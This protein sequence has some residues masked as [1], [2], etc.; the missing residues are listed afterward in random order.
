V[1]P[2]DPPPR[3]QGSRK[4]Q[5]PY[6]NRFETIWEYEKS[7]L[8]GRIDFFSFIGP[9]C[10]IC[11]DSHCYRQITPYWRYAIELF[12]EF[13]KKRIPI[14]RFLCRR[15]P[16]TFSLL[17]IQLIPYCQYTVSAVIGTLLGGFGCWQMGQQGFWGASTGVDPDSLLTPWLVTCWLMMVVRGFQ[18]AHRVLGRLYDLSGI[19]TADR[20]VVWEAA[21]GYFPAFGLQPGIRWGPLL[22]ALLHRYS[23][24]TRQFLFG[25]SSQ[26]RSSIRR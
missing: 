19:H 5:L 4:I 17:P 1:Q 21:A 16:A 18:R 9:A 7:F 11:G 3:E 13:R 12:P 10:P 15:R 20:A 23:R 26:Q 24:A 6:P 22:H 2:K 25:T 8:A 14:A